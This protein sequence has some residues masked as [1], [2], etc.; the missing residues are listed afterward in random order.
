MIKT[1]ITVPEVAENLR[2]AQVTVR[3]WVREQRLPF[4]RLGSR[5]FFRNADIIDF[6]EK[7]YHPAKRKEEK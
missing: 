7:N 4:Y 2:I 3:K 6:V 1:M 5:I